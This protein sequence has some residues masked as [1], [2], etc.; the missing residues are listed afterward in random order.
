MRT[1]DY[2]SR[3]LLFCFCFFFLDTS[4]GLLRFV[5]PTF[6]EMLSFSAVLN[7]TEKRR[8]IVQVVCDPFHYLTYLFTI[9]FKFVFGLGVGR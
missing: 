5:A 9:T 7:L 4:L 1:C 3:M 8:S 6:H 2:F